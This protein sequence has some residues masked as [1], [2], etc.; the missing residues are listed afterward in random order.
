[1]NQVI[2]DESRFLQIFKNQAI[3][4]AFP[5]MKNAAA[6]TAKKG[7]KCSRSTTAKARDLSAIKLIIANMS[8]DKKAEF[9]RLLGADEVRMV[10]TNE[11]RLVV[12]YTF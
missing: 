2:L 12:D 9:K 10:Y 8:V 11:R 6:Q 3:L 1:M 4:A 5:F 7:C